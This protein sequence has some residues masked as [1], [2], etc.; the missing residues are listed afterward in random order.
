MLKSKWDTC[1][2]TS[3]ERVKTIN[4]IIPTTV[5]LLQSK[6]KRG[7]DNV[8]VYFVAAKQSYFKEMIYDGNDASCLRKILSAK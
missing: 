4:K 8:M 2:A 3:L 5:C 7:G 1:P 6:K